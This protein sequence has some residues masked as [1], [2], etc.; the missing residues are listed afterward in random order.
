MDDD[1]ATRTSTAVAIT[2]TTATNQLPTV[3]ITSPMT[4]QSFTAP[5]S[6]TIAA[7]AS[8]SDGTITGVD[9]Y[10]GTQ[11]IASDSTSPYTAAWSNVAAG[12]YSLTAVA[13]DNAGGTRTS[14]AIAVTV[15]GTT[16]VWTSGDIGSPA[17]AGS[18]SIAGGTFTVR[19]AGTN[20]WSTTDQFQ[21]V[22]QP[23]Q[24]DVEI[25]A[26]VASLSNGNPGSKAGVMIRETLTGPSRHAFLLASGG[27]GWAF[28][29]RIATGGSTSHL[30]GPGT[31]APGWVRLVREGN[32]FT[33]YH[34]TDGTTWTLVGT[35]TIAM[36]STVYVGL[37]VTSVKS[38]G[39]MTAT[40]T[41]VTARA[42]T[43]GT[44][45]PPTVSL[46]SPAPGATFTAP[47]TITLNAAA[48]DTDGTVARVEF[49][50]GAQLIAADT[51]NPY[52][53]TWSNAAAG[54]YQLTAR[55]TDS[56]GMTTTSSQVS[57][58]VTGATNQP[59][60]VSLTSPAG[61]ATFTAPASVAMSATA[62][63]A[64][65]TVA[66]V[67]FYQ[68][69]TLIGSDT[70]S[71]YGM[72]WGSVAAGSY[73]LTAVA[74]DNGGATRTSAAVSVTVNSATNQ[75]PAVA[76]TSPASRRVVHGAGDHCGPGVGE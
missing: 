44:N 32:L 3:A 64:D 47:A 14:T 35:D 52:S 58:T 24:G 33:A 23:L 73:Q 28:H 16:N 4:G 18:T 61:G 62:A 69:T 74:R 2:V 49:Y 45:Q 8:D 36:A 15:T 1:G 19:G 70:S 54:T 12:S 56:D 50:Q 10:V 63:D 42:L 68:G 46:T 67:D 7:T 71:P 65:G 43:P 27:S 20:V 26:R 53:A 40:F 11:L 31:N 13:R 39:D 38:A 60:T 9:F 34:S 25:I 41:N 30:G 76:V 75:A 6:F 29:R 72:T 21:F 37:A 48:S 17:L 57:V 5:S 22:S 55:A 66:Q 59:P 51:T